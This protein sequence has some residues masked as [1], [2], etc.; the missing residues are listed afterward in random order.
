MWSRPSVFH[1]VIHTSL[2]NPG[3]GLVPSQKRLTSGLAFDEYRFVGFAN[4][5][6][7]AATERDLFVD[8]AGT[9]PLKKEGNGAVAFHYRVQAFCG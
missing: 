6:V 8:G 9:P 2:W 3:A 4:H 1:R 7:Y 5:P